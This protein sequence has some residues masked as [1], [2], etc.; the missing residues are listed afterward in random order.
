VETLVQ[1]L[2]QA[3]PEDASPK[4]RPYFTIGVVEFVNQLSYINA[5]ASLLAIHSDNA[6]KPVCSTDKARVVGKLKGSHIIVQAGRQQVANDSGQLQE[7]NSFE[8]IFTYMKQIK[9]QKIN[10]GLFK[11]IVRALTTCHTQYS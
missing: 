4:I 2:H 7:A 8:Q 3:V 10:T 11:M 6:D 1:F 9:P 5:N